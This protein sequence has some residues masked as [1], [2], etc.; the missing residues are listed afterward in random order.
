MTPRT[1][2]KLFR[3]ARNSGNAG[4]IAFAAA[5]LTAFALHAGA[6]LPRLSTPGQAQQLEMASSPAEQAAPVV[7]GAQAPTQPRG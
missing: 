5:L 6:F 3:S 1:S 2:A 7:A 4:L